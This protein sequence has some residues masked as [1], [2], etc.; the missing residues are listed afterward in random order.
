MDDKVDYTVTYAVGCSVGWVGRQT[1]PLFAALAPTFP[2]Y[3]KHIYR[4]HFNIGG[5]FRI[6]VSCNCLHICLRRLLIYVN[7]K[8]GLPRFSDSPLFLRVKG[9]KVIRIEGQ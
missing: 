1:I 8:N 5:L 2:I 7:T 6:Y 3:T 4:S 9:K